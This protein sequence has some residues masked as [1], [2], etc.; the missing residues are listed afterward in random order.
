MVKGVVREEG[1][2]LAADLEHQHS[3]QT[4]A[5]DLDSL[6]HSEARLTHAASLTLSAPIDGELS[7]LDVKVGVRRSCES[8][9]MLDRCVTKHA[10]Q[11]WYRQDDSL[12]FSIQLKAS[13]PSALSAF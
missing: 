1:E 2:G 3:I 11:Y 12:Y 5:A 10:V 13:I 8:S 9:P 4:I 7:C 6:R